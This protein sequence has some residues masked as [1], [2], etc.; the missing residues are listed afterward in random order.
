MNSCFLSIVLLLVCVAVINI[1]TL[2]TTPKIEDE[3]FQPINLNE[4]FKP[5]VMNYD[6]LEQRFDLKSESAK[7]T[8]Q[9][10]IETKQSDSDKCFQTKPDLY[11]EYMMSRPYQIS[12][13][14]VNYPGDYSTLLNP[15]KACDTNPTVLVIL[16]MSPDQFYYRYV[17]RKTWATMKEHKD[18]IIQTVFFMG[19]NSGNKTEQKYLQEE[20][21]K[22]HDIIQFSHESSYLTNVIT[23]MLS[24]DWIINYCSSVSFVVKSDYDMFVNINRIIDLDIKHAKTNTAVG[25]ILPNNYVIRDL[26]HKNAIPK[27]IFRYDF[28]KPYLSGCLYLFPIDVI[29]TVYEASLNVKPVLHVEDAYFGE[30]AS[31]KEIKL[32][33]FVGR[34]YFS[35]IAFKKEWYRD[36]LGIHKLSPD[37]IYTIY[38]LTR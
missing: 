10:C 13:L 2:Q 16:H 17:I 24:Y 18:H 19:Q 5:V 3:D 22:Y 38:S 32:K 27:S 36:V 9:E 35:P 30:I 4:Q 28:F 26:R 20:F 33:Q 7:F 11:T 31:E 34:L 6:M 21:N 37:D 14:K 25:Y 12:D 1:L 15:T 8:I 29:K 23:V